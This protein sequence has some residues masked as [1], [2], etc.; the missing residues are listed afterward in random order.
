MD[1]NELLRVCLNSLISI[2]VLFI[3]TK[4]MGK[5]Q[6]SQLSMFDYINGITIGSIGAEFALAE[7]GKAIYAAAAMTVYALV[8]ILI[9]YSTC[10]SIALRRLFEGRSLTL[11]KNGEFYEK[12]FKRTKLDINEF[13]S[14][15][16]TE[17]YYDVSKIE[18]AVL[19]ANG[20]IS[21]LPK[22]QYRPLTP[23]DQNIK[24]SE[25]GIVYN[26]IIDGKLIE[27]NLKYAGKNL[28]WLVKELKKQGE[29]DINKI[30]LATCDMYGKLSVF[31]K[32][33]NKAPGDVW[34]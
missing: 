31:K 27:K 24:V 3:L 30:F 12:N 15:M 22:A 17:G 10:K 18:L 9:S 2:T 33:G 13:L 19:E 25:E 4:L 29:E 23:D 5:R 1:M 14:N 21:F 34:V 7:E 32:S 26:I 6:I 28:E 20:K 11:I 8:C 16:R